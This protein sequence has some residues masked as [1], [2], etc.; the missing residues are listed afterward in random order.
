[1]QS[2]SLDVVTKIIKAGAGAGKTT[3]LVELFISYT[4]QFLDTHQRWPRIVITTF[5]RK[6][7]QEL[8]ERILHRI[9][10]L[11]G[12][13]SQS[14]YSPDFLEEL[15]Y[16]VNRKSFVQISTIHGTLSLYLRRVAAAMELSP[17]FQLAA[18]Q[19]NARLE[20]ILL[21]DIFVS[22]P[23]YMSLLEEVK[24]DVIHKA[25]TKFYRL[26]MMNP[27]LKF[28]SKEELEKLQESS[29]NQMHKELL[30]YIKLIQSDCTQEKWLA[31]LAQ[32]E[33]H[34]EA[35]LKGSLLEKH[36]E[37]MAALSLKKESFSKAKPPFSQQLSEDFDK[38]RKEAKSQLA[39]F[40]KQLSSIDRHQESCEIFA[41]LAKE[42]CQGLFNNKLKKAT[43]TMED[44]ELLSVYACQHYPEETE[45]FSREWDFWM[46]DEYQDT[47]PIQ[48]KILRAL[49]GSS[50]CYYVGDP[51]QS[52]YLFRGARTEVFQEKIQEVLANNGIF[53]EKL[54]NYRS[55]RSVLSFINTLFQK[56]DS[57]MFSAMEVARSDEKSQ[58]LDGNNIQIIRVSSEESPLAPEGNTEEN[59]ENHD[60]E[61]SEENESALTTDI[62]SHAIAIRIQELVKS[63]AS[64]ESICVLVRTRKHAES[65]ARGLSL[66]KI[67]L[68]VHGVGSLFKRR[69]VLDIMLL[70]KFL[71]NPSDNINL[72]GLLR[73]PWFWLE[74]QDIARA[75]QKR[76]THLWAAC[77]EEL[78]HNKVIQ[79]LQ[80]LLQSTQSLGVYW[81]LMKGLQASGFMDHHLALDETQRREA[82]VWKVLTSLSQQEKKPGFNWIDYVKAAEEQISGENENEDGDA[83]PVIEPKR[84]NIM[85]VHASKGLQFDHIVLP[86]MNKQHKKSSGE[87]L[88]H[89]EEDNLWTLQVMDHA[90]TK[91]TASAYGLELVK[92]LNARED[93]ES[94]RGFYV[95]LTRAKETITLITSEKILAQSWASFLPDYSSEGLKNWGDCEYSVRHFRGE[96]LNIKAM[97]PGETRL[98]ENASL[99]PI[100]AWWDH[101]ASTENSISSMLGAKYKI[102]EK[103]Y[104]AR[105]E[106][107]QF[108]T[109][110]HA[111]F[112]SLKYQDLTQVKKECQD[113]GLLSALDYVAGL[114]E[115]D[116]ISLIKDGATEFGFAFKEGA[117]VFQ[118]QIDL[119]G[120]WNS[121]IWI[122]DYK[123]GSTKFTEQAFQQ[124]SFYHVALSRL[125]EVEASAKVN[126][127]VVYPFEEKCSLRTQCLKES[128]K[129]V[130]QTTGIAFEQNV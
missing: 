118:G 59:E 106:K 86:F 48:V 78:S 5:T 96:T 64:F 37:L 113:S 53:D 74:D 97:A 4:H 22:N 6:A 128:L 20:R 99:A 52:I 16:F 13:N 81:T 56:I 9:V 34:C 121:Q 117:K 57:E 102:Q 1:M 63:G 58:L 89:S 104:V 28:I 32:M 41:S 112:E 107:A 27:D 94:T 30:K 95:A 122:V 40:E 12:Q 92:R 55:S 68:Q 85:T 47:S 19:E 31:Y 45:L 84:V 72:V 76:T 17:D 65:V 60:D 14:V 36:K 90:E 82:N 46:V 108:G 71:L 8:K 105:L 44:L 51:Q 119:W 54:K 39:K 88:M 126:L 21:K 100:K 23:S 38:Y 70:L 7:T 43:I 127:V 10:Q 33:S 42:F 61:A 62:Q 18:P 49:I 101:T 26:W 91:L 125:R 2:P 77:V 130:E 35:F 25:L 120:K 114:K 29:L 75:S 80:E 109:E 73:T 83:V 11:Q 69:E 116:L 124:L 93:A 129:I 87:F 123:T 24:F 98:Q 111:L 50:P 79:Q 115:L 3:D 66:F 15:F 67:P 110:T 103:N